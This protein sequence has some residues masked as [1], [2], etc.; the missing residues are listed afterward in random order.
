MFRFDLRQVE[1]QMPSVFSSK[2]VVRF[3][4]IDAAGVVYFARIL[5]YCHELYEDW[6]TSLEMPLSRVLGERLWI[7]PLRHAEADFKSPLR[8]G[9]EMQLDLVLGEIQETGEL[10]LLFRLQVGTRLCASAQTVHCFLS[11]AERKR[12]AVPD[13]IVNALR[14]AGV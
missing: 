1:L 5:E 6:L 4:D 14:A 9:D 2:R 7:A 12:I 10:T 3:N 8:L 13:V 11:A